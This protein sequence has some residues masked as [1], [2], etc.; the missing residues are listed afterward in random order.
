MSRIYWLMLGL[1]SITGRICAQDNDQKSPVAE[2]VFGLPPHSIAHRFRID[3]GKGNQLFVELGAMSDVYRL[4]NIDSFLLVF[5]GDMKTFHDSLSDPM[6]TKRID[7]VIDAAGEKKIRIRQSKSPGATFLLDREGPAVLKLE[8]DTVNILL[9]SAASP[10]EKGMQVSG[11]RYDRIRFVINRYEELESMV[12]TG[13]NKKVG[14]LQHTV[15]NNNPGYHWSVRRGVSHMDA[16]PSISE[17]NNHVGEGEGQTLGDQLEFFVNV[18]A[19]N[20]RN[21]FT[22]SFALGT[23]IVL[24]SLGENRHTFTAS[25]EP[26]FFFS[27]NAQG[28]QQTLRNDLLTVSYMERRLNGVNRPVGIPLFLALGYVVGRQGNIFEKNSF[29]FSAARLDLFHGSVILEPCIYFHDF[30][31]DVTPGIRLSVGGIF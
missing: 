17:A 28:H 1:L 10:G 24:N 22:P 11:I 18:N 12:T 20:F 8:Q 26:M 31:Q 30:C 13:L 27:S 14:L 5:I 2:K 7:Y 3:L 15:A 19:Q 29:R 9:L 16:D 25:W 6:T 23:S 21:Y 4:S